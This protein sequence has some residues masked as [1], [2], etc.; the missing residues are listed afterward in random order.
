M[1]KQEELLK[2]LD[3]I[4]ENYDAFYIAN[5]YGKNTHKKQFQLLEKHL[6]GKD[7]SNALIWIINEYD[8]YYKNYYIIEKGTAF[9]YLR[10]LIKE[11]K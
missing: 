6:K 11:V 5:K 4:K 7:V 3:E 9:E 2:A 10:N 8:C 1:S